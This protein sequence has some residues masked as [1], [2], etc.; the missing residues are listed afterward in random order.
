[1]KIEIHQF[2]ND[3]ACGLLDVYDSGLKP[4]ARIEEEELCNIMTDAQLK[5]YLQGKYI[6]NLPKGKIIEKCKRYFGLY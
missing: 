3:P 6:L 1:M 4:F 2:S 5:K